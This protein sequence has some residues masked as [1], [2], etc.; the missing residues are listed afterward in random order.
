VT[1][2]NSYV[3]DVTGLCWWDGNIWVINNS[4]NKLVKLDDNGAVLQE[5]DIIYSGGTFF[6][7]G[8]ACD[9]TYFWIGGNKCCGANVVVKYRLQ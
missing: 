1:T 4:T 9:G 6:P 5:F 8:L 2:I 7:Y 3:G